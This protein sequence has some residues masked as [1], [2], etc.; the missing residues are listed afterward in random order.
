M[1]KIL[2][3]M[4]GGVDSAA[5][6]LLLREQGYLAGGATM[7]LRD[8]GQTQEIEDA[9][10]AAERMGIDFHVFDLR[11]EFRRFVIEPFTEVYR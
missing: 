3:A 1:R 7:L 10:S 9:R 6:C 8:E 4:S 11:E 2:T 5:A